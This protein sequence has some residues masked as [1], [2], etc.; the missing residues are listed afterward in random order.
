MPAFGLVIFMTPKNLDVC[1]RPNARVLL[2]FGCLFEM[3]WCLLISCCLSC[4]C[5]EYPIIFSGPSHEE[6]NLWCVGSTHTMEVDLSLE[7]GGTFHVNGAKS[8]SL[9]IRHFS[10]V[11]SEASQSASSKSQVLSAGKVVM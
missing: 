2:E 7:S 4:A 10:P 5:H 8:C 9:L 11:E 1:R 3:V 6:I